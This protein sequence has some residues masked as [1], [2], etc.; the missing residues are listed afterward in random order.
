MK[1]KFNVFFLPMVTK[2]KKLAVIDF[3]N[4]NF[5]GMAGTVNESNSYVKKTFD[6]MLY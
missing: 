6:N 3:G 5:R 2:K 4:D 1:I